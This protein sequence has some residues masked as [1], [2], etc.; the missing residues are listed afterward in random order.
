MSLLPE[1]IANIR[2][3]LNVKSI[4]KR[5]ENPHPFTIILIISVIM[6]VMYCS[7]V[8]VFKISICGEWIDD[9][10]KIH[11]I[12]HNKWTDIVL[13]DNNY[14]GVFRGNLLLVY[15]NNKLQM[16]IYTNN[17][18]KWMNGDSWYGSYKQKLIW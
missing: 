1:E 18:I 9:D 2:N 5:S 4:V 8:N 3:L 10:D 17:I 7:Y 6:L 12:K 11:V 14:K 13:V 16:G 15:I